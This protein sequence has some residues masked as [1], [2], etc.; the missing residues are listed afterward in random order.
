MKNKQWPTA[1]SILYLAASSL[2]FVDSLGPCCRWNLGFE[3]EKSRQF[4]D[5]TCPMKL[6]VLMFSLKNP[7]GNCDIYPK[8]LGNCD[9]YFHFDPGVEFSHPFRKLTC[10][11]FKGSI[12]QGNFMGLQASIFRELLLMGSDSGDHNQLMIYRYL[13]SHE[14]TKV[15]VENIP[16]FSPDFFHESTVAEC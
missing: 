2:M 4:V 16:W 12:L 15:F 6:D 8:P 9:I 7:W 3:V 14:F 10:P 11:F 1:S 13:Q 5:G